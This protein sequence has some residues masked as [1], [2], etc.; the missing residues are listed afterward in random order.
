MQDLPLTA[1]ADDPIYNMKAVTQRTG[2]PAATLRAWERRYHALAPHRSGGNYRL[3]SERDVAILRWLQAQLDAGLSISRAVALLERLREN[4]L[5]VL[6]SMATQGDQ[7]E[8]SETAI[9][10]TRERQ[11][12]KGVAAVATVASADQL[13]EAL[14]QALMALDEQSAGLVLAEAFALYTVEEVCS[15]LIAPALVL[16]GDEWFSHKVS[17]V[18]EHFASSYLMGRLLALFNAQRIGFGP[19]TLVSCA[20]TERHELGA[21]MLALM[22]RRAGHNVRYLGADTPLPDLV[23]AIREFRPR[24]VALSAVMQQSAARLS[25]LALMLQTANINAHLVFGGRAFTL[26]ET[27]GKRLHGAFIGTDLPRSIAAIEQLLVTDPA[28]LARE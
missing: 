7:G 11:A 27:L 10:A 14:H 23:N 2:I 15:N 19:L 17:V 4:E 1:Y 12:G 21:L 3:Y 5:G 18:Q 22:L 24:V 25:E 28:S 20:P 6:P 13:L 26:D 16:I 9:A 8:R